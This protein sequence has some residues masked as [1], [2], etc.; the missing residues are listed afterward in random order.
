MLL[1]ALFQIDVTPA[2]GGPIVTVGELGSI[3]RDQPHGAF[4]EG[5]GPPSRRVALAHDLRWI[6]GPQ[7]AVDLSLHDP[8]VGVQKVVLV[9]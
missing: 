1:V 7:R 3:L 5:I 9:S 2:E 8:A 6:G 4:G